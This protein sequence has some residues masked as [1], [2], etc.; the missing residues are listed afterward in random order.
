M[1]QMGK[2][3]DIVPYVSLFLLQ[4]QNIQ[5]LSHGIKVSGRRGGKG[6]GKGE[7]KNL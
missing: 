3:L 5:F 4:I 1:P 2:N 7:A 6:K